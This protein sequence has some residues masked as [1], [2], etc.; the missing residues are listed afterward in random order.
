MAAMLSRGRW[1][2]NKTIYMTNIY[3]LLYWHSLSNVM[4]RIMND[5]LLD[6]I[7]RAYPNLNGNLGKATLKL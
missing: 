5:I 7:I 3:G 1:V 4:I 2:N 6:A